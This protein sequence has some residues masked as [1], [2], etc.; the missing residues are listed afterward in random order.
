M[1]TVMA[2]YHSYDMAGELW[3]HVTTKKRGLTQIRNE[4][5]KCMVSIYQFCNKILRRDENFNRPFFV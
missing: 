5:R 4:F 3:R 2:R 1:T